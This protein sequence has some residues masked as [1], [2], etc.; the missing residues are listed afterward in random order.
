MKKQFLFAITVLT[1]LVAASV[2]VLSTTFAQNQSSQRGAKSQ[3]SDYRISG[4]Y[5]HKN[6]TIFLVHGKDIL[7]GHTF[8]TLQEALAQKKVIV[9]ETKDVNELAIRNLSNQDIYVQ[10]GDIVRGGEQDR[11][12]SLDFIVPP[13]SGRMPIAAFCVESG[14]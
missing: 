10:A 9:Y 2:G 4:P 6:L 13:R 7:K 14:R 11:M 12:I 8:L 5:V 3:T 1:L